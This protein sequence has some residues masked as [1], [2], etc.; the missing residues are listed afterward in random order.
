MKLTQHHTRQI[1]LRATQR[2]DSPRE[3][4]AKEDQSLCLGPSSGRFKFIIYTVCKRFARGRSW[5]DGSD[6]RWTNCRANMTIYLQPWTDFASSMCNSR[7]YP[8]CGTV[9]TFSQPSYGCESNPPNHGRLTSL[10]QASVHFQ[11]STRMSGF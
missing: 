1:A 4:K 3:R 5:M 2:W 6:R 11:G 7:G 9:K 8:Y 10:I